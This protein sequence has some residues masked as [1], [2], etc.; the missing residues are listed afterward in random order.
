MSK[1]SGT[2][3]KWLALLQEKL[4][5][6]QVG[7]APADAFFTRKV[8]LPE[9]LQ[10]E[11]KLAYIELALEGNAPFP[12]E[13]LAWGFLEAGESP[14]VF[15]YAT[16][17]SRLRRL[18][19][20][21]PEKYHQLF[22]GFISLFG[23]TFD[24]PTVRFISQNGVLSALYLPAGNPVPEKI[25]SRKINADLLTDDA[26]LEARDRLAKS[27]R[28]EDM[29]LEDGLWLGEGLRIRND[30]VP[31]FKHRHLSG[32]TPQGIK[33]HPLHLGGNALW[34]AD[35]RDGD[36]ANR[37]RLTRKRSLLI[38]NALRAAVITAIVLL[39]LQIGN[40][41]LNAYNGLRENRL[42]ELEPQ[43]TRVENK[44][45]LATR[46]TQSTEEDLKPFLLMESINPLRPDSIYFDKVRSRAFNQ[47][48]IE[49]ES[50]EGVTPVNSF[51]D[52]INQLANI[53]SVENNSRTRNN[54][55][56][57]EFLITFAELP[58]GPEGGFV[59]PEEEDETADEEADAEENG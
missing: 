27:I 6:R 9:N 8:E 20:D 22:P 15:V 55:T 26:L 33:E 58:E 54:Q 45:T 42:D 49:G 7:L 48:E 44:L 53:E 57:F 28:E 38:W 4:P 50:T 56:S 16:P 46:L 24:Q 36:F 21:D 13:Q 3:S 2:I 32:G 59:I 37:E 17:K 41:G 35:L 29:A 30:G 34:S 11:D 40:F 25:L 5:D 23:E 19:I 47:L 31:V 43:A 52:S 18:E 39:L 12:M 1:T 14:F 51:A 10:W